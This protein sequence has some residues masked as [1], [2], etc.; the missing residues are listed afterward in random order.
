MNFNTAIFYD[1]ENLTKGYR[2]SQQ[3]TEGLSLK[4]ILARIR[5]VQGIGKPAVQRAYANWSDNR[6]WFLKNDLLEL[7]IDPVQV[8]NFVATTYTRNIA[9]IQLAVDVM[10]VMHKHPS[11]ENIVIVSGDGGYASLVK[12]LHEYGKTVIGCAYDNRTN[13]VFKAICDHF[14]SLTDPDGTEKLVEGSAVQPLHPGQVW[15]KV[16]ELAH[17]LR[18][19]PEYRTVLQ[20]GINAAQLEEQTGNG[21]PETGRLTPGKLPLKELQPLSTGIPYLSPGLAI[22]NAENKAGA[23]QTIKDLIPFL[24]NQNENWE[25]GLK[26]TG[27]NLSVLK[28]SIT[29]EIGG[30]DPLKFGFVKFSEFLRFLL[31]DSAFGIWQASGLSPEMKLGYSKYV[32]PGF[33]LLPPLD[34][35]EIHSADCY[36]SVLE[37]GSPLFPLPGLEVLKFTAE[38]LQ[39]HQPCGENYESVLK[40]LLENNNPATGLEEIKQALRCFLAAGCFQR[41]PEKGK[42]SEQN[43][44]L[45][46]AYKTSENQLQQ[47]KAEMQ[48]KILFV[49]GDCKSAVFEETFYVGGEKESEKKVA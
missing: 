45:K 49:L 9:D 47:L 31:K 36:R 10:D 15:A 19:F 26:T 22:M 16:K 12:K 18:D 35:R 42:L 40:Q 25:N 27:V 2:V 37:N 38:K 21:Q 34:A 5:S 24:V 20:A 41:E 7:G 29:K 14:I 46:E 13:K 6:L 48:K 30:F 17:L 44:T 8:F 28:D 39:A 43:L 11:I 33:S 4:E 32:L 1:I 3:I 23:L